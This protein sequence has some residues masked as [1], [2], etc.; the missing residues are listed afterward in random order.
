MALT[1]PEEDFT[2]Q[3][4]GSEKAHGLA[5]LDDGGK[6]KARRAPKVS[7]IKSYMI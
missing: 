1:L 4:Y 5:S 3:P 2:R 6:A 7:S